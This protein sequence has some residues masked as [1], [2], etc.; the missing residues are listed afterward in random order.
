M[1]GEI[2]YLEDE[3]YVIKEEGALAMVDCQVIG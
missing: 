3:V 1:V 2:R